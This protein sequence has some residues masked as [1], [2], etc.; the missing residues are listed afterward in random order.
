MSG[1]DFW[2]QRRTKVAAEQQAEIVEA[3]AAARAAKEQA[4]EEKSDAELLE[5]LN[6]P[7]PDQMQRGDDFSVF[8]KETIPA[9]LRTRAL[10]RLWTSNPVLANVDGLLDYGEDF[11][12]SAMVIEN[13]QTAYQVG[14][15]MTAH[16]EELARQAEEAAT[17][18]AAIDE[19]EA[20]YVQEVDG[21]VI[22]ADPG[23]ETAVAVST[24]R[25]PT[26][27]LRS[28]ED[29]V[30][31]E[32]HDTAQVS[33]DAAVAVVADLEPAPTATRRMRFR[34]AAETHGDGA[35]T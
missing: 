17:A 29:A 34:F 13:L 28:A 3:A 30:A 23:D 35:V 31:V 32:P 33:A 11:T 18:E 5:E 24:T 2:S 6:L 25:A 14:K 27:A 9:R 16:V 10:R 22:E 8:L 20:V 19:T 1:G 4:L 7:D 21:A 15:G 12:D 26:T